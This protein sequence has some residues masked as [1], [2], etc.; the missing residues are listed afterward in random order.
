MEKKK[1]C[2]KAFLQKRQRL[3]PF[4]ASVDG[5][6]GVEEAATLKSIASCIATKW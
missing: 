3:L 6:L 2:I 5:I 4:V 1:I